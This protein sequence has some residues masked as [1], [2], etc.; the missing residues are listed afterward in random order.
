MFA[1]YFTL[2]FCLQEYQARHL[3]TIICL[4]MSASKKLEIDSAPFRIITEK[5][6]LAFFVTEK[7]VTES[8]RELFYV[9]LPNFFQQ[10][11]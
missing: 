11:K 1:R 7:L 5:T 3:I 6:H 10:I 4:E 9:F 2:Y 8:Q